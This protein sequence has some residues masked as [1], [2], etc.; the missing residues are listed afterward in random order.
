MSLLPPVPRIV[1]DVCVSQYTGQ[2][3]LL[4]AVDD[5]ADHP[6]GAKAAETDANHSSGKK[7]SVPRT[8]RRDALQKFRV[9][10]GLRCIYLT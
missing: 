9:A 5:F 10:V 2:A 3:T 4:G 6:N 8:T 1:I 7:F